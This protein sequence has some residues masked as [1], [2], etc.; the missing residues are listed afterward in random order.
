MEGSP[1]GDVK[2]GRHP[3]CRTSCSDVKWGT[4][5]VIEIFGVLHVYM[6]VSCRSDSVVGDAGSGTREGFS[7]RFGGLFSG[8]VGRH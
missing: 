6:R 1:G 7:I 8:R 4:S 3:C 2:G 5:G